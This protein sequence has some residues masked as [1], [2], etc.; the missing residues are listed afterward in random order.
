MESKFTD[1][2][3]FMAWAERHFMSLRQEYL[4]ARGMDLDRLEEGWA[5]V[6]A[7]EELPEGGDLPDE[8][9]WAGD[10]WETVAAWEVGYDGRKA[11]G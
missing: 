5:A 11:T 6:C 8:L 10:M 7:I 3:E 9:E 4:A 1:N 2:K